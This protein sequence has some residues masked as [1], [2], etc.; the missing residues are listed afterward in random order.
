MKHHQKRKVLLKVLNLALKYLELKCRNTTNKAKHF[1]EI[2][3][4]SLG[5]SREP[6]SAVL[7]SP[8]ED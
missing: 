3:G 1:H 2:F 5:S 6:L 4:V 8:K 7:M